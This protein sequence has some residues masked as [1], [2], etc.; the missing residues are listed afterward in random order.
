MR[1]VLIGANGQL[2]TDLRRRLPDDVVALDWPEFDVQRA[3]QVRAVLDEQRPELVINCA[4]QTNVDLC[5]E[6]PAATLAVNALGAMHVARCA[7]KVGAA[8]AFVSTDYVFGSAGNRPVAYVEG[9]PPGPINVYG[10]SK[11]A[12]EYLTLAYNSPSLV[13]RTSGLYGHAGA[14]G[15]GGNFVETMLRLAREGKP[16]RVVDDQRFSP[17]STI[18]CAAKLYAL[19]DRAACGVYHVAAPDN[20][21]WFEFARAI[22]EHQRLDVDLKPIP[23][24]ESPARARRPAMSA[25]GSTR[26]EEA[27][28]SPCRP[29][30]EMLHEYLEARAAR[31]S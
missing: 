24:T 8:V 2:G 13:V 23:S 9:D 15:K 31:G 26:L 11:L 17:T 20:C 19:S 30:R 22:F 6:E 18:E 29:W 4:A 7:E 16:I 27:E 21:T 1:T 10:V 3:E 25:L 12:G 5:E 28:V 14:R